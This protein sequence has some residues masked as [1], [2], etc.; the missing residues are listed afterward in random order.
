[1]MWGALFPSGV[2]AGQPTADA[3]LWASRDAATLAPEEAATTRYIALTDPDVKLRWRTWAAVAGLL[4]GLSLSRQVVSPPLLL[5]KDADEGLVGPIANGNG[6]KVLVDKHFTEVK[7]EERGQ[8]I[9]LRVN[10]LDYHQT[11]EQWDKLGNPSLEPL[12]HTWVQYDGKWVRALA[13]WLIEPLGVPR[14]QHKIY[15]D[16][17]LSL[18]KATGYSQAPVIEG[19]NLVWQTAIDFDRGS[20]LVDG[21]V[22]D[23]SR[24]VGY[25]SWLGV[26]NQAD[27]DRVTR[28]VKDILPLLEAISESG[29]ADEPRVVELS[30]RHGYWRTKDQV[31]QRG[32]GNRNPLEVVD[33][34]LLQF[35]A[36][37]IFALLDNGFWAT[38][39]FDK[40]GVIQQSAP[41]GVGYNHRTRSNDGKIHVNLACLA[42]HDAKPGNGGLMP[43]E[44]FFRST[45]ATPG[46]VAA[47]AIKE[48]TKKLATFKEQYLTP[49]EP[50]AR[51]DRQVYAD[52]VFQANGLAPDQYASAL[53]ATFYSWDRALDRADMAREHGVDEAA[54]TLALQD[55]IVRNGFLDNT[56]ANQITPRKGKIGRNQFAEIYSRQELALRGI[57]IWSAET[58]KNLRPWLEKK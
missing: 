3:H 31:N 17:V 19:R 12:Y 45:F 57:P 50:W 53:V 48:H 30:G 55:G 35:D 13:P 40:D 51:I 21:K 7:E 36:Q 29:V 32:Q 58:K 6:A 52:A 26:K 43:F 39:L 20:K 41:D 1:M 42:C 10:L 37:E 49:L 14:E 5:L 4:N 25:Y 46:P 22:V 11:A 9:L 54:F 47:G 38:G 44:P 8:L 16:A 34:R 33:P 24:S 23:S 2:G 28:R 56:S 18:V 15:L 27:F